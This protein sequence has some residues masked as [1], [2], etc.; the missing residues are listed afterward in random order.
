M[1]MLF[2]SG[3]GKVVSLIDAL[4]VELCQIFCCNSQNLALLDFSNVQKQSLNVEVSDGLDA[5][6]I[7]FGVHTPIA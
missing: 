1:S 5:R 6:P 7:V 3:L 2:V 4:R